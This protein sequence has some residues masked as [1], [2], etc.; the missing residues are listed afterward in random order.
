MELFFEIF[1]SYTISAMADLQIREV[2]KTYVGY[3]AWYDVWD[4]MITTFMGASHRELIN[5]IPL[6][7]HCTASHMTPDAKMFHANG[8]MVS[9]RFPQREGEREHSRGLLCLII[10]EFYENICKVLDPADI[11]SEEQMD[12]YLPRQF[13]VFDDWSD[14]K[15]EDGHYHIKRRIHPPNL[16]I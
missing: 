5:K 11:F 14:M 2:L 12:F 16:I 13:S 3:D 9:N 10:K 4:E 8:T 6:E 7:E 1:E 15:T